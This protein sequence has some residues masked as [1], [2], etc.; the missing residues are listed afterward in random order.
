[1]EAPM[2]KRKFQ[3]WEFSQI[4]KEFGYKRHYEGFALLETWLKADDP[5]N[6]NEKETL[7]SLAKLLFYNTE[8]WNE[9]EL[10]FF[11]ISPL[12]TL[13][14]F[15][16]KQYKP[17]TQRKFSAVIDDWQVTGIVDFVIAKG[18]QHP[19]QPFFFLHEYK[20]ERKRDNDPLGQLLIEMLVAQQ[21]NENEFPL[22]GCYVVGRY[23]FF[24]VLDGQEYS[25]SRS[26]DGSSADDI[27]RIFRMFRFVKRHIEAQLTKQ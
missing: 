2:K 15:Q 3:D 24:V 19:E 22:Y 6:D 27:M 12:I 14:G 21:Q 11:F 18:E 1:M 17:F 16:H 7:L 13:V 26:H 10:K 8:S 20:Q 9:D 5:I 25:V 4:H 23:Y